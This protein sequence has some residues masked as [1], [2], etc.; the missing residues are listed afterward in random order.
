MF[1]FFVRGVVIKKLIHLICSLVYKVGATLTGELA[2]RRDYLINK[3]LKFQR[4]REQQTTTKR[5]LKRKLRDAAMETGE[6]VRRKTQTGEKGDRGDRGCE[7]KITD[8]LISEDRIPTI[9][10]DME[11]ERETGA[12]RS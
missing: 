4:V 8:S 6:M 12:F 11:G 1:Y 9:S 2:R 7:R 3:A 10:I 5:F